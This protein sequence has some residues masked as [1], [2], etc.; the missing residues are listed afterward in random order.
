MAED[1]PAD[2]AHEEGGGE[3]GEGREEGDEVIG[4]REEILPEDDG[5][6]AIGGEVVPFQDIADG[7]CRRGAY[8][9]WLIQ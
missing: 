3:N 9:A 1:R 7:A 2:R 5:E 6:K 4:G 8:P